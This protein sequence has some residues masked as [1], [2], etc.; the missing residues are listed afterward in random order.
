MTYTNPARTRTLKVR[1]SRVSS[2]ILMCR[3]KF[4]YVLTTS[5]MDCGSVTEISK[6]GRLNEKSS[7]GRSHN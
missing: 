5:E 1:A 3:R 4:M 2:D 6:G 7:M